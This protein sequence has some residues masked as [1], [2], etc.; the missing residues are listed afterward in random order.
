MNGDFPPPDLEVPAKNAEGLKSETTRAKLVGKLSDT[1]LFLSQ[2]RPQVIAIMKRRPRN[3][4][5]S[6]VLAV[7]L[8]VNLLYRILSKAIHRVNRGLWLVPDVWREEVVEEAVHQSSTDRCDPVDPMILP[9][10]LRC[11][12]TKTSGGVES[13]WCNTVSV[14][15]FASSEKQTY[16][17]QNTLALLESWQAFRSLD[18]NPPELEPGLDRTLSLV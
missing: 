11:H 5:H 7:C 3:W 18:S 4:F 15:S 6:P 13:L 8:Y 2:Y 14:D 12:Q 1:Q 10:S 9:D 16:T 17:C